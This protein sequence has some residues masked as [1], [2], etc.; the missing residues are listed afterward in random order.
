LDVVGVPGRQAELD[1]PLADAPLPRHAAVGHE[2]PD[3]VVPGLGRLVEGGFIDVINVRASA[4]A[5][6]GMAK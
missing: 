6:G 3:P 4:A 2:K 1:E 5:A